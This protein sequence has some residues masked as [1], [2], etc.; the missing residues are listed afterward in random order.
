MAQGMLGK[1]LA[2][3]KKNLSNVYGVLW[4]NFFKALYHFG[5]PLSVAYG[6]LNNNA[7]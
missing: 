5:L 4:T 3:L 7:L 6:K 1:R 2:I